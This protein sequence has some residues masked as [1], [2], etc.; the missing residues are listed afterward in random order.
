VLCGTGQW[1]F[2]PYSTD[3]FH[4][5]FF[6]W[7]NIMVVYL[8]TIMSIPNFVHHRSRH[9]AGHTSAEQ[10][11]LYTESPFIMTSLFVFG[12]ECAALQ[13][14]MSKA[15]AS[16]SKTLRFVPKGNVVAISP[17]WC[18]NMLQTSCQRCLEIITRAITESIRLVK[19][20]VVFLFL[21]AHFCFASLFF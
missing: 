13:V 6:L 4:R 17:M 14:L 11:G 18:S 5:W 16:A 20:S 21:V 8:R 12:P 1:C 9:D 10:T 2:I 19:L 15:E 3:R 7:D